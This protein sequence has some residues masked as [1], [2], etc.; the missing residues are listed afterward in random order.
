MPDGLPQHVS[1][2]ATT[3]AS[4]D[5]IPDYIGAASTMGSMAALLTAVMGM[6]AALI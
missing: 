2:F 6:F 5:S 3:T 4:T 1:V